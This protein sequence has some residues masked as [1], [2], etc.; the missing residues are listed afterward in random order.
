M[1]DRHKGFNNFYNYWS[2][3]YKIERGYAHGDL[4]I[5]KNYSGTMKRIGLESNYFFIK[6]KMYY[7]FP[8]ERI[9]KPLE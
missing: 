7:Q 1:Q 3:F 4:Y 5:Y 6:Y 9:E 8:A 2:G